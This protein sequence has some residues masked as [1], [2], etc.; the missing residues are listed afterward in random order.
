MSQLSVVDCGR[1]V[2]SLLSVLWLYRFVAMASSSPRRLCLGSA[3]SLSFE[4]EEADWKEENF[5]RDFF[6]ARGGDDGSRCFR[7][8][9]LHHENDVHEDDHEEAFEGRFSHKANNNE[10]RK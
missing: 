3:S 5:G 6:N 9:D 10:G 8:D 4:E 7:L 1:S 2:L